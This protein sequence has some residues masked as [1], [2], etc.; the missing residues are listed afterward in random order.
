MYH[1]VFL[2]SDSKPK[3]NHWGAVLP[4]LLH[5]CD[6]LTEREQNHFL[7][8]SPLQTHKWSSLD[9]VLIT[10]LMSNYTLILRG[11]KGNVTCWELKKILPSCFNCAYYYN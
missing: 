1:L 2:L 8:C 7:L 6:A 3:F 9:Y 4:Q 5:L 10:V 11:I